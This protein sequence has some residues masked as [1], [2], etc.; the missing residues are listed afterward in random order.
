MV[1]WKYGVRVRVWYSR[2]VHPS[3][4]EPSDD[5]AAGPDEPFVVK[6]KCNDPIKQ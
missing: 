6:R 2:R 5:T 1:L 4:A 3:E